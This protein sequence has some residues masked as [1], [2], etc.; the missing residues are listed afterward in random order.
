[1]LHL[2]LESMPVDIME[3]LSSKFHS[4]LG[5]ERF[6]RAQPNRREETGARGLKRTLESTVI[7][8]MA[9]ADSSLRLGQNVGL[10]MVSREDQA[11]H[12]LHTEEARILSPRACERKRV[13]FALGRTAAHFALKQIGFEN[14]PPVLRGQKGEPIWPGG[15]VGSITHC[16]PWSVAVAVQCSNGFAVGVDLETKER[17]QGTDISDLVCR[18]ADLDWVRDGDFQERLTMIFSA[19]EAI[20]KALYPLCQRYIDFKEVELTWFPEQHRFRGEFLAPLVPNVQQGQACAVY[21]LCHAE[22]IFS[23]LIHQS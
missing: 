3:A 23:C 21:C 12:T 15:I 18:E 6:R 13:E 20:Y 17:M 1:M 7:R 9:S 10:A 5:E 14:P 8:A 16:Y 19:K 2:V 11:S 22:L 4:E